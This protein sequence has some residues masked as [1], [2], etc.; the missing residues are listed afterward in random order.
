[1]R[2]PCWGAF[3]AFNSV[4]ETVMGVVQISIRNFSGGSTKG[5]AGY[6]YRIVTEGEGTTRDRDHGTASTIC[7]SHLSLGLYPL[8]AD[9]PLDYRMS[10]LARGSRCNY[11]TA[12]GV[13]NG[14]TYL[15]PVAATGSRPPL[16]CAAPGGAIQS[17]KRYQLRS[18]L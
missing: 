6:S 18:D 8:P 13:R 12:N 9:L 3:S 4:L 5:W 7:R 11:V 2:A 15:S 16:K 14:L 17:R 1:M 10:T